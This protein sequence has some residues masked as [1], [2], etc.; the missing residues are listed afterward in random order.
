MFEKDYLMR[1]IQTLLGAINEIINSI[2]EKDFEG[3]KKQLSN[4]YRLLGDNEEYFFNSDCEE[5]I[6]F[7]R[8]KDVNYLEKIKLL[9]ELLYLDSTIEKNDI[10]W[11]NKILKAQTLFKYYMNSS[12]VFSFEISNR[13]LLIK[14]ELENF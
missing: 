10:L 8:Q 12:R 2:D 7:F 13:L 3:A 4:S 9:A 1:L 6:A 11:E 14:K 5:L